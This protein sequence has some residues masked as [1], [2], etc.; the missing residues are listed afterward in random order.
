M[1]GTRT[2]ALCD[3]ASW[4][5]SVTCCICTDNMWATGITLASGPRIVEWKQ[6]ITYKVS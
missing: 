4:F 2:V 5:V 1:N 3:H 6:R